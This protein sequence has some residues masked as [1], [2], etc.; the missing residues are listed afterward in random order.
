[1]ERS[2]IFSDCFHQLAQVFG[3]KHRRSSWDTFV[4][5]DQHRFLKTDEVIVK[6]QL[7]ER[8]YTTTVHCTASTEKTIKVQEGLEEA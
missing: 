4:V 8:V 2:V 6:K 1:M 7:D 5:V 3:V